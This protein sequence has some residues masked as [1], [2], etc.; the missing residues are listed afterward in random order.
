[1]TTI[2]KDF[3]GQYNSTNK[4]VFLN[5][6]EKEATELFGEDW[7]AEDDV[8][9]IESLI[10]HVSGQGK[11]YKVC[12]D[13]RRDE[14]DIVVE[15]SED[16]IRIDELEKMLA[17]KKS[18]KIFIDNSKFMELVS[19][20][21]EKIV[22]EKFGDKGLIEEDG[23]TR[24]TEDAQDFFNE[25][26]DNIEGIMGDVANIFSDNEMGYE[27]KNTDEKK[28]VTTHYL[29]GSD[30]CQKILNENFDACVEH[31]KETG[32][33]AIFKFVSG[34]STPTQLLNEYDGWFEFCIITKEEYNIL[35]NIK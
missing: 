6:L 34:E 23:E 16:K 25:V 7:E 17:E 10:E 24:Y 18:E 5:E 31:C 13:E 15:L 22:H 11:L 27:D 1:M 14:D 4:F 35:A 8:A 21:S 20:I 29:F 2:K 9:Q 26:Y 3:S 19:E 28:S 32:D 30:A 33:F 12:C